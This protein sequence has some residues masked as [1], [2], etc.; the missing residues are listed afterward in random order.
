MN[1]HG[2]APDEIDEAIDHLLAIG[3]LVEI[4]DDCFIP[5]A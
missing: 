4:D 1:E 5:T 3:A 2:V